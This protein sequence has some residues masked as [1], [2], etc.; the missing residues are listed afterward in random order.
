[1]QT[2]AVKL[3]IGSTTQ[4]ELKIINTSPVIMKVE[5]GRFLSL[6]LCKDLLIY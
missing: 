6:V 1:M 5:E 4:L 2:K 3:Q